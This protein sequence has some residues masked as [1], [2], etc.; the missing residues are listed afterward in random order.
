LVPDRLSFVRRVTDTVP[1]LA[2]TSTVL[3]E[4]LTLSSLGGVVSCT[5]P[6]SLLLDDVFRCSERWA[7][8]LGKFRRNKRKVKMKKEKI[9]LSFM[10]LT[11]L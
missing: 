10:I 4:K 3:G 8:A 11:S 9:S 7:E 2:V 6:A 5:A 1:S